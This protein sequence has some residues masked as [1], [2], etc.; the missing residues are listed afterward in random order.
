MLSKTASRSGNAIARACRS[1]ITGG[2]R[3]R[4]RKNNPNSRKLP[5]SRKIQPKIW[6]ELCCHSA[7]WPTSITV[8]NVQPP[9]IRF[10][11]AKYLPASRS[12]TNSEMAA[13]HATLATLLA[14]V[15]T[16]RMP[17]QP[18]APACQPKPLTANARTNG[19]LGNV[20][21][22]MGTL[23]HASMVEYFN[24]SSRSRCFKPYRH[25]YERNATPDKRP[26][27]FT[28]ARVACELDGG[29]SSWGLTHLRPSSVQSI[30]ASALT[31]AS[32]TAR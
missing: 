29:E 24:E 12:G 2:N 22:S 15:A 5:A 32:V 26:D 13:D 16:T 21:L 19:K 31:S 25:H 27:A 1:F 11:R 10:R 3:M 17:I 23:K 14:S 6:R 30:R 28:S 8:T 9:K 18:I 4:V 7:I 20:R